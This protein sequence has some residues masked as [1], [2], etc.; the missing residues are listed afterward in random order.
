MKIEEERLL[1]NRRASVWL[2]WAEFFKR[3]RIPVSEIIP[4]FS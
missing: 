3:R 1:R 4:D 2:R